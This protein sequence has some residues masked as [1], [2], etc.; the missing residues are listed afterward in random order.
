M[1]DQDGRR[2]FLKT[3]ATTAAGIVVGSVLSDHADAQRVPKPV[4]PQ[5]VVPLNQRAVLPDG[6]I[7]TRAE[8]LTTLGLDPNVAADKWL[9]IGCG[10]NASGLNARDAGRLLQNN[11]ITP[12]QLTPIQ[13]QQIDQ[14]RIQPTQP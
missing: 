10:V 8:I 13:L 9:T 3:A 2:D 1:T 6:R 12:E 4:V 7:L 5:G 14:I 11:V